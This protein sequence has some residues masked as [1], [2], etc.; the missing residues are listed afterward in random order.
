MKI[1]EKNLLQNYPKPNSPR[2]VSK[3]LRT[4]QN[5]IIA[6]KRDKNFFDGDRNSGYGGFKYDG[7]WKPIAKNIIDNYGLRDGSKVLQVQCE[8]GFLLQDI[9][10]INSKIEVFGTETSDYAL[11]QVHEDLRENVVIAN[12]TTLPFENDSFDLVI[13]LGVVYTFNLVD[14]ITVLKNIQRI[15]KINSFITLASYEDE[16]DYFL[17]KYWTLLGTTILKKNEWRQ[18]LQHCKFQ[19]DYC[20]TNAETLELKEEKDF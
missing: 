2:R 13:A 10:S 8:K 5:R 9:K 20:F 15:S 17:F 6:C 4:I 11:T 18:V 3:N 14:I 7:R 12:A 19:G 16:I 1:K